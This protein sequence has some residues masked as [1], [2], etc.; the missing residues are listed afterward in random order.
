MDYKRV[1]QGTLYAAAASFLLIG[2]GQFA[3]QMPRFTV[4]V[5]LGCFMVAVFFL[6][7]LYVL[8][9]REK[10]RKICYHTACLLLSLVCIPLCFFFSGGSES[11]LSLFFMAGFAIICF[12]FKDSIRLVLL[13]CAAALYTFSFLYASYDSGSGISVEREVSVS[14]EMRSLVLAGIFIVVVCVL[15]T[16]YITSL[17][18]RTEAEE[19]TEAPALMC[20]FKELEPVLETPSQEGKEAILCFSIENSREI[21]ASLGHS[22]YDRI[23]DS[24]CGFFAE[25]SEPG[26]MVSS[27][28][29]DGYL[30]VL[31][32][33]SY[34]YAR[35][36]AQ[37][38]VMEIGERAFPGTEQVTLRYGIGV[39]A[40]GEILREALKRAEE[41]MDCAEKC[42]SQ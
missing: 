17:K 9:S 22:G 2:I 6:M 39:P 19:K 36:Y 12:A 14:S 15:Q 18:K 26:Q 27:F 13:C 32:G 5:S 33:V 35:E 41:E 10:A 20:S 25:L 4:G 28:G 7:L 24:L 40:P 37:S 16:S 3:D 34:E 1:E 23:L 8:R 21:K 42:V 29:G 30:L 31:E 11:G 38:I